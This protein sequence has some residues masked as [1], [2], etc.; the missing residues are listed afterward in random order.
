LKGNATDRV[1]VEIRTFE[2]INILGLHARP[3]AKLVEVAKRYKAKIYF[4]RDGREVNGRSLLG[5]LTLACPKGSR[6][7]IRAEGIDARE[8]VED[9]GRLIAEKFGEE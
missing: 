3:A 7:A 9:L 1:S 8:A 4:E 6:I 2:I 5:I